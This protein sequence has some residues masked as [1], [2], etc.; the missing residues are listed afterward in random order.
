MSGAKYIGRGDAWKRPAVTIAI[1][2]AVV[3]MSA[4]CSTGEHGARNPL[5]ENG[6]GRLAADGDRTDVLAG[7]LAGVFETA[8]SAGHRLERAGW[9]VPADAT[10]AEIY[11]AR[12]FRPFWITDRARFT[13]R[14]AMLMDRL[15]GAGVEALDP[16]AYHVEAVM[17][18]IAQGSAEGLAIAELMLSDALLRFAADLAGRQDRDGDVL[19]RAGTS[20]DFKAF[21]EGLAPADGPYVRLREALARYQ[22]V[23]AAGGWETLATGEVLRA[24]KIDARVP[25]LRRRLA[26]TGDLPAEADTL[27][28]TF[29][30]ALE[31]AVKKFQARHGLEPDGSVG[32]GTRA[33]LNVTADRRAA[34]IAANMAPERLAKAR[35]G[36][37]AIVV[38]LAAFE[39][40]AIV[41]GEE[42]LRSRTIIGEPD[43]E[44]PRLAS[45]VEWLEINPTWS[46]PQRIATEEI[47]PRLRSHGTEYLDK[48]G[49]R[50]F[51]TRWRE[52]DSEKLD[53]ASLGDGALPF[54]LR[55]DPGPANPLGN[56][57]FMFA[58]DEAIFLHDTRGRSLF[59]RSERALSHGCVRVEAADA[60]ARLLLE[61][62]DWSPADYEKVVKS[63]QTH[64]VRLRHPMPLHIVVRT[65]WVE[66][67]GSVQFRNDPYGKGPD[68]QLA[69]N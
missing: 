4:A 38:N 66:A 5:G 11:A 52:L 25:V 21:L 20:T 59:R 42:V 45:A 47:V 39:L 6:T 53:L 19:M 55:Q 7:T 36:E 31:A 18:A 40:V 28:E 22:A 48:R 17:A 10:L 1:M 54:I 12:D 2:L 35:Y 41:G 24:G 67:D 15:S 63:G 37:R 65:A 14:G 51:D 8:L 9:V 26:L 23:A 13:S 27:S 43:W 69:L 57:K 33:A 62:L 46:V 34:Q 30:T 44:T 58:N 68:L 32:A 61:D 16:G 64:R 60:L 3:L 29:D 50:L 56:V 49:F